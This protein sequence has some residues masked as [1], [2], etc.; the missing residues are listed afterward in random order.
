M[1]KLTDRKIIALVGMSGAGKS[2]VCCLFS[3]SGYTVIDCDKV[4][5]EVVT[6]DSPLLKELAN[7]FSDEIIS[8]DGTLNRRRTSEL[9][10]NNTEK[11][12]MYNR[13]FYPYI[14]YNVFCKIRSTDSDILLDAPT[15]FEARLDGI[16]D[17]I[18][19]VC[20]DTENCVRRIIE[21]DNIDEKLARARLASQHDIHW[22]SE[23]A[24]FCL[25]NDGTMQ[26]LYDETQTII[27][28]LKGN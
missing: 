27:S 18:V 2:T 22:F 10:F 7:E 25:I 1:I 19:A 17:K 13:I 6:P 23:H 3:D 9:I 24:D 5:R 8:V 26:Q 28:T 16:C 20:A 4:S 14:T 11:R 12:L 15:L 21:R